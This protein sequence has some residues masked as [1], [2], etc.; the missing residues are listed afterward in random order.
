[1]VSIQLLGMKTQV[2]EVIDMGIYMEGYK[3]I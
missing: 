1:M 3:I 2:K